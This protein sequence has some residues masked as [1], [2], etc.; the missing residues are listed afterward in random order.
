M[1]HA[2]SAMATLVVSLAAFAQA[3]EPARATQATGP[4]APAANPEAVVPKRHIQFVVSQEETPRPFQPGVP[5]LLEQRYVVTLAWRFDYPGWSYG[6]PSNPIS[7]GRLANVLSGGGPK[8]RLLAKD[9]KLEK[10]LTFGPM[11][12]LNDRLVHDFAQYPLVGVADHVPAG[13]RP[14]ADVLSGLERHAKFWGGSERAESGSEGAPSSWLF[15]ATLLA[16]TPER[17][18]ALARAMVTL[19]DYG[20][21]YPL[22]EDFRKANAYL[23]QR[24][25]EG[26]ES[27]ERLNRERADI[28][29]ELAGLKDVAG[30]TQESFTS[31]ASQ[32]LMIAVDEAGVKARIEAC[33]KI[34][35]KSKKG[36]L[37]R[38]RVEQVETVKIAAE[39][40][41]VGLVAKRDALESLVKRVRRQVY[42]S[43]RLRPLRYLGTSPERYLSELQSKQKAL[44]AT[45]EPKTFFGQVV[46][47]EK[48]GKDVPGKLF[49]RKIKWVD[50]SKPAAPSP[51]SQR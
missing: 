4:K 24:L 42:L 28:E 38:S 8:I 27:P 21:L 10:L 41:L 9:E 5:D 16:P 47:Q 30:F 34:L 20:S 50:P 29:R 51:P 44:Q 36:E 22:D 23:D 37:P 33:K 49:I 6:M 48:G 1:K 26:R 17:A 32:G 2:I 35:E 19:V 11:R 39:I 46:G 7:S 45:L 43:Q 25:R 31:L 12:V 14:P 18:E 15:R 13:L 40:E 3:A